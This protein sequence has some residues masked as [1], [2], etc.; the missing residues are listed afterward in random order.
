MLVMNNYEFDLYVMVF[1]R[2][3]EG[4]VGSHPVYVEKEQIKNEVLEKEMKRLKS[5]YK[6]TRI[7]VFKF[8]NEKETMVTEMERE[9][10]L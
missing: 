4:V 8:D 5:V 2:D 10:D 7:K 6:A 3:E 9:F 1:F